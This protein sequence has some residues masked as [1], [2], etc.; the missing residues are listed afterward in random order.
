LLRRKGKPSK[1]ARKFGRKRG[2]WKPPSFN[3]YP[4]A[5]VAMVFLAVFLGGGGLYLLCERTL[6]AIMLGR[7]LYPIIPRQLTTQTLSESLVAMIFLFAGV[8]GGYMVWDGLRS[9][10]GRRPST[11]KTAVGMILLAA[12]LASLY[13]LYLIKFPGLF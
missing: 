7:Q 10:V 4:V 9:P 13:I 11:V 3:P 5:V 1:Y 2:G 6:P 12:S 8:G